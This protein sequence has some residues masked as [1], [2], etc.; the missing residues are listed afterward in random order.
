[1]KNTLIQ[2]ST[3]E[4]LNK[5]ISILGNHNYTFSQNIFK[6]ST[7]P[8]LNRGGSYAEIILE[9]VLEPEHENII[10]AFAQISVIETK[11][12]EAIQK[13]DILKYAII[14]YAL[15]MTI[16]AV[17]FWYLNQKSLND[18]N[19]GYEWNIDGTELTQYSTHSDKFKYK[20]L[21]RNGDNNFESILQ[22][23]KD[24]KLIFSSRDFYEDGIY[25][26]KK[27]LNSNGET[28]AEFWDDDKDGVFEAIRYFHG[29][30][31]TL[32]LIW[33]NDH[34]TVH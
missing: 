24:Q 27:Q 7:F 14:A 31:D 9:G 29:N 1:M 10:S 3:I 13:I 33:E 15:L 6:D 30:N 12:E 23:N 22:Y 34:Y 20:Y 16:L 25:E 17:R 5:I 11:P 28:V 26:Y 21:D 4:I 8:T 18:K 2:A 32:D 19:F